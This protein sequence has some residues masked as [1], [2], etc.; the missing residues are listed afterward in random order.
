M[1]G[2]DEWKGKASGGL[3]CEGRDLM[4]VAFA[5]GLRVCA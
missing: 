1:V 3:K 5:L 4:V 2:G